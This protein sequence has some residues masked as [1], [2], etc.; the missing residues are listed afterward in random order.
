MTVELGESQPGNLYFFSF[1]FGFDVDSEYEEVLQD[2]MALPQSLTV[3]DLDFHAA[4][5]ENRKLITKKLAQ[6]L[7]RRSLS[8][9]LCDVT[10]NLDLLSDGI[11]CSSI[12]KWD[13]IKSGSC[14]FTQFCS[15][16]DKCSSKDLNVEE[17]G[18]KLISN[19][20]LFPTTS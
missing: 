9:S 20:N 14:Y 13:K 5:N 2:W 17:N 7:R 4:R 16:N 6:N 3:D 15:T 18:L 1:D 10:W 8:E 11:K 12:A 19:L